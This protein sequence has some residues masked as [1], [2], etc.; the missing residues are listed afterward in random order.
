MK[1]KCKLVKPLDQG[2][3]PANKQLAILLIQVILSLEKLARAKYKNI[4]QISQPKLFQGHP[5]YS[6]YSICSIQYVILKLA[7][8]FFIKIQFCHIKESLKQEGT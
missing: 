1:S 7:R 8:L 2:Q 4:Q 5:H 6:I 3:I